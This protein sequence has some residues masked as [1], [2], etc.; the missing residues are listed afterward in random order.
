MA[1]T[2]QVEEE[3]TEKITPE[4][5]GLLQEDSQ[6][7]KRKTIVSVSVATEDE[8]RPR[9]STSSVVEGKKRIYWKSPTTMLLAFFLGLGSAL[10]L[11]GYYSS[12]N[13]KKVGDSFQQSNALR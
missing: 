5:K 11:H 2:N 7:P 12:L 10:A 8:E 13:G 9:P 4:R 6:A 3:R 1:T